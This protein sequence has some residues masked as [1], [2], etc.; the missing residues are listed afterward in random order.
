MTK[1]TGLNIDFSGLNSPRNKLDRLFTVLAMPWVIAKFI[2]TGK[3][4]IYETTFKNK[5]DDITVLGI[6]A[7]TNKNK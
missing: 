5:Q 2:W 4:K 6:T 7:P 1:F 3:M